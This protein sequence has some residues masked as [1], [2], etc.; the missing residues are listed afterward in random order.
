MIF[1]FLLRLSS[2]VMPAW[3]GALAG[4][5]GYGIQESAHL[6]IKT[7][8]YISGCGRVVLSGLGWATRTIHSRGTT[9]PP[10]LAVMADKDPPSPTLLGLRE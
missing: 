7:R 1:L 4:I 3:T 5:Y 9:T 10:P 8:H 2:H 6:N